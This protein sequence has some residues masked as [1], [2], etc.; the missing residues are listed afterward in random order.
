MWRG[1]CPT[2]LE[3]LRVGTVPHTAGAAGGVFSP[4]GIAATEREFQDKVL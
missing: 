4:L 2:L 3:Q 1:Q